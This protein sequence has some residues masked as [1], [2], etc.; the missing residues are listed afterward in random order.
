MTGQPEEN[1]LDSLFTLPLGEFTDA[2]N[3]LAARLKRDKRLEDANR[4]KALSK[5]SVSAW[6]VNQLYWKHRDKF[7]R[8]AD[9]GQRFREAQA[10]VFAGKNADLRELTETRR[11]SLS[12]LSRLAAALLSD[13]GHNPAP[14]TMRRIAAT[15]EALS[16][17]ALPEGQ[18]PG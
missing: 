1:E 8:L 11:T 4:V 15:L 3:A 12:E 14:E 10:S 13:S 6:T 17:N 7:E 16:L 9:A 18:T 2:R 5:P